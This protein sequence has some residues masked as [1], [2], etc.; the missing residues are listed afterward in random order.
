MNK[1][2]ENANHTNQSLHKIKFNYY[3]NKFNNII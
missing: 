1:R 2:G 3:N